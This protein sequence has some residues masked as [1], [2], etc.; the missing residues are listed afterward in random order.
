MAY[1][2]TGMKKLE[3]RDIQELHDRDE[4]VGCYYLY[5]DNTEKV[6]EKGYDL[7]DVIRHCKNGGEIGYE[8]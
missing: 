7:K 3:W 8:I 6:I 4:L 1:T 5:P 2:W